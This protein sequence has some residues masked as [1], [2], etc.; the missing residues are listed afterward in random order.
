[1]APK[2]VVELNIKSAIAKARGS[3]GRLFGL[4]VLAGVFIGLGAVVSSTVAH[5]MPDAGL[6]RL[7]S[8]LLF[9]LGLVLTVLLGAEL[10]TGNVLMVNAAVAGK[11][12]WRG[13]LRNWGLVLLGNLVG[14]VG[15]AAAMAYFGQLSIGG[16]EL[17]VFSAKVAAGKTSLPWLNALMLGVFCNLLVCAAIYLA[18]GAKTVLGKIVAIW[19][20]IAAFVIAGFEHSVAN[21]YYIPA[22]IFAALNPA[23][24]EVIATAGVDTTALSVGGLLGN[25]IPVIIGNIIGGAALGLVLYCFH[26]RRAK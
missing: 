8:G 19:V 20:P 7:V 3:V 16:G 17:A 13:L 22:G 14:A 21:M 4:G 26:C 11:I 9:P 1:M 10:F 12:Q 5:S 23:Y 18:L 2:Q 25:L 24:S 6:V 15:L